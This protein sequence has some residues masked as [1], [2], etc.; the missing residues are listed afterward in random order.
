MNELELLAGLREEIPRGPVSPRAESLL[1]AEV[2]AAGNGQAIPGKAAPGRAGQRGVRRRPRLR[3]AVVGLT[4][5]ALAAGAVALASQPQ[6]RPRPGPLTV[7]TLAQRAAAA[8]SH[9]PGIRAGQWVY[10]DLYSSPGDP[11]NA[12]GKTGHWAT[13]D[14]TRNAFY[15]GGKLIVGPWSGWGRLG[16]VS[17]ASGQPRPVA[18]APGQQRYLKFTLRQWF[19]PYR[20]LASLPGSPHALIRALAASNPQGLLWTTMDAGAQDALRTC[21]VTARA[22]HPKPVYSRT[23][24]FRA[25]NV[26]TYLLSSYVMPP[27]LT[28]ELYRSLGDIPGIEVYRHLTDVAGRTGVGFVL[29]APGHPGTGESIILNPRTYQFMAF[30]DHEG[31]VAI[32]RQALVSGPGRL[33]G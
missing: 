3:L 21:K 16:C 14:N 9:Q 13:A 6:P 10:R 2:G 20:D 19:V 23:L 17:R 24:P 27:R 12:R 31:G 28:A 15:V 4:A 22:C 11:W 26:I 8:A 7:A 5:A 30:G 1:L 18:C 25:F 33:P 29:R 32:L